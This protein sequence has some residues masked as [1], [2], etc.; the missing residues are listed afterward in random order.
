M[1]ALAAAA[2]AAAAA[3]MH[4]NFASEAAS[5]M[6]E[7]TRFLEQPPSDRLANNERYA[8][9]IAARFR[10]R[11][12][13]RDELDLQKL[14]PACVSRS[15]DVWEYSSCSICLVDFADGEELRRT[16]CAGGH[17]FHPRCIRGWLD[18]SNTSCPVCRGGDERGSREKPWDASGQMSA[19][20]LAE[21]VMRRMRSG[22]V[23][24][25]ISPGNQ[26]KAAEVLK[27]IRDPLPCLGGIAEDAEP[28][29]G[30]PLS[31]T[32]A[33]SQADLA[34]VFAKHIAITRAKH[35]TSPSRP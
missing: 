5:S 9:C 29:S 16:P 24:L 12:P 15:Q 17:A 26:Q 4:G 2:T 7:H 21:Y 6:E 10:R 34:K 8:R 25:T 35:Q 27:A 14:M 13:T 1:M 33:A 31:A 28:P 32:A 30:P 11:P 18:R 19:D 23:D 22:K 3:R 20:A